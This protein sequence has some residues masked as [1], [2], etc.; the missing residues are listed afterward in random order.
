MMGDI[1]VLYNKR[2]QRVIAFEQIVTDLDQT[3]VNPEVRT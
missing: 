3:F 1:E 2:V